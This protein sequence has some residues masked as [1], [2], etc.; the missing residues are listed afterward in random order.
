MMGTIAIGFI[1]AAYSSEVL[2]GAYYAIDKGQ[3]LKSSNSVLISINYN[4][5]LNSVSKFTYNF[6]TLIKLYKI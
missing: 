4:Y 3:V 1:S 2:R 5:S 6:I